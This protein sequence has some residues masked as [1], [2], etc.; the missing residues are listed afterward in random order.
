MPLQYA[1]AKI[2]IFAIER[3]RETMPFECKVEPTN[4]SKEGIHPL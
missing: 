1:S 3:C 4:A 2:I